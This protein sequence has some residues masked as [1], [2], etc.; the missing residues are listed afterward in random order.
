MRIDKNIELMGYFWLPDKDHKIPGTL[1]IIDG[2]EISLVL[3]GDLHLGGGQIPNSYKYKR[4]YGQTE[5]GKLI[6]LIE[7]RIKKFN[8]HLQGYNKSK[9]N[10]DLG[11][12]GLHC[13]DKDLEKFNSLRFATDCLDEWVGISGFQNNNDWQQ[14]TLEINYKNPINLI[15]KVSESID[16]HIKFTYSFTA[17]QTYRKSS[18]NQKVFFKLV[19]NECIELGQLISMSTKVTYFL[20]FAMNNIVSIKDVSIN[21]DYFY[22]ELGSGAR[23]PKDIEVYYGGLT[24][25]EKIPELDQMDMLFTFAKIQ[26]NPSNYVRKWIESYE[27]IGSAI[28]LYFSYETGRHGFISGKFLDLAR[29]LETYH[30]ETEPTMRMDSDQYDLLVADLV[31]YC[32]EGHK[33]WLNDKLKHA[34]EINLRK[35]LKLLIKPFKYIFNS[36]KEIIRLIDQVVT[37]RHY[38]THFDKSLKDKYKDGIELYL[39]CLKLQVLFKLHM[40]KELGFTDSEITKFSK[41]SAIKRSLDFEID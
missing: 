11:L 7:C 24:Y 31:K 20:C 16:L 21:S 30:R 36:K 8:Y 1:K 12:I 6:T 2:G 4:I 5:S 19:S 35:R 39:I 27:S 38:L 14:K 25:Q 13:S 22:D 23:L 32:P 37:T 3:L 17:D 9:I 29:C 10:A 40:L 15:I 26:T 18:I 41:E 33:I 28:N 34:N